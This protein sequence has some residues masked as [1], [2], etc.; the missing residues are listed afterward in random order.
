MLMLWAQE[1]PTSQAQDGSGDV[2]GTV[3]LPL[4]A[5]SVGADGADPRLGNDAG[6]LCHDLVVCGNMG[7]G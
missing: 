2:V 1:V 3:D 4:G 6:G 5:D 7:L